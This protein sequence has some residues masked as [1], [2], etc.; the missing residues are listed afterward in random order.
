MKKPYVFIGAGVLA[1]LALVLFV[2]T[3]V[4]YS[5]AKDLTGEILDTRVDVEAFFEQSERV[6]IFADA[7]EEAVPKA[8]EAL[9]KL[10]GSSAMKD[11]R[12]KEGVEQAQGEF[13]KLEKMASIWKDVDSL[14]DLSDENLAKLKKSESKFLAAFAKEFE[15]YM[16]E[17]AAYKEKYG[18]EK[19][20]DLIREYGE[21]WN[22]GE[23][24]KKKA[25][26]SIDEI[27]GMSRDDIMAFYAKIKELDEYLATK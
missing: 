19:D 25:Q 10:A 1:V 27:F 17:C 15:D 9:R 12:V 6:E 22:K 3:R 11:S 26:A 4:D 5:G 16:K 18:A 21:I 7:F 24:L 13:A 20:D 14:G 2:A 23:D 8:R